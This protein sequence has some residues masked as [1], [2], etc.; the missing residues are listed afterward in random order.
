MKNVT[1]KVEPRLPV[2]AASQA[3]VLTAGPDVRAIDLFDR[4]IVEFSAKNKIAGFLIRQEAQG[5]LDRPVVSPV[6]LAR[7][8]LKLSRKQLKRNPE[9]RLGTAIKVA[10]QDVL[11]HYGSKPYMQGMTAGFDQLVNAMPGR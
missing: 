1:S 10:G 7:T 11:T 2:K 6:S 9:M 4:K 5:R 3:F 8:I